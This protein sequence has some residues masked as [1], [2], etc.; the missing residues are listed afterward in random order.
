MTEK[1]ESVDTTQFRRVHKVDVKKKAFPLSKKSIAMI[2][3][4]VL[5]IGGCF[6]G[7][8]INKNS[9]GYDTKVSDNKDM[10]TGDVTV[11]KQGFFEYLLDQSGAQKTVDNAYNAIANKELPTKTYQS[12][13]DEQVKKLEDSYKSYMGSLESYATSLGYKDVKTFE[14]EFVMPTTKKTVLKNKYLKEKYNDIV[15]TYKPAYIKTI[16]V[17]KESIAIKLIKQATSQDA[18][19][20]LMKDGAY[21]SNANDYKLVTTKTDTTTLN[22]RI[23][24]KLSAFSKMKTDGV[25][26]AAIKQT[27][28]KYVVVF[29]YNTDKT[30]NKDAYI[31]DLGSVSDLDEDAEVYYLKK[32]KFT[33]Y[34][35][36][37]KK[38]IKAINKKYIND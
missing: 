30:K 23:K 34:D 28:K 38:A 3:V 29:V 16:T 31:N 13:I 24:N 12:Q 35:K 26:P 21:S 33:V 9:N 1:K 6:T 2:I 17:E 4:I 37:L 22:K 20:K 11:S 36:K 8:F 19:D 15:K 25:Y 14:K 27:T 5:L 7:Y 18:F 10:I 32:Y